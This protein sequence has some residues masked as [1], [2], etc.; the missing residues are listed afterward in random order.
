VC[1]KK[2]AVVEVDWTEVGDD[3]DMDMVCYYIAVM[4]TDLVVMLLKI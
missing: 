2:G 1:R 3:I 4:Y